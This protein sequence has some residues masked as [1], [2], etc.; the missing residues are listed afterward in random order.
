MQNSLSGGQVGSA[1]IS[2]EEIGQLEGQLEIDLR[3]SEEVEEGSE[4]LFEDFPPDDEEEDDEPW[5][6]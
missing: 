3:P 5:K 6:V 4:T 1:F 2:G